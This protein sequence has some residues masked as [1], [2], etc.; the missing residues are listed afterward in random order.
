MRRTAN[1]ERFMRLALDEAKETD[2]PF[3]A[4]IVKDG[5]VIASGAALNRSGHSPSLSG[6]PLKPACTHT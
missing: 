5:K 6:S 2:F 1:E 4:V 3:G